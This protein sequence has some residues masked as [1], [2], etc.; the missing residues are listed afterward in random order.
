M[1]RTTAFLLSFALSVSA[2]PGDDPGRPG[3]A[4]PRANV[5]IRL[6]T[7]SSPSFEVVGLDPTILD[8]L[9]RENRDESRWAELFRVDVA[10][11]ANDA[12]DR[13]PMLGSYSVSRHVIRFAP[14]FRLEPGLS[15]RANFAPDRLPGGDRSSES[16][17]ATFTIPKPPPSP[18][19]FVVRVD[20]SSDRLPENLLKFYV[21]FSRPMARGEIYRHFQLI[22]GDGKVVETPFLEFEQEL[23][24]R[25][26]TRLTLI[27][28]PGRV[29]QG[30]VPREEQGPI[31]VRGKSYT[32]L[33]SR[34]LLDAEGNP[35]REEYRKSF[36]VDPPDTQPPDP[37][38]WKIM[39]PDAGSTE[40]LSITF[41]EPLDRAML[42]RVLCV[43]DS[44]GRFV[45]GRVTVDDAATHWRFTPESSWTAGEYRLDVQTDLED[46]VGNA[47]GRQFE[48]DLFDK[49]A[50]EPKVTADVVTVPFQVS[51]KSARR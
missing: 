3:A 35:L 4:V 42:E 22:A 21:H 30:L 15:Y 6:T 39:P 5:Q 16:V 12:R 11:P 43:R 47:I 45:T 46:L 41:D 20:P 27:L 24:N 36:R 37:K 40:P 19:A 48:V 23:W 49:I 1:M 2:A 25:A 32:F 7:E 34:K 13:P 28:D 51:A 26:G 14:R 17:S 38:R 31:L 18:A 44:E 9:A 10:G 33:I 50:S 29:K 8:R